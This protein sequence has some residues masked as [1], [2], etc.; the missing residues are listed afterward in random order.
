M[1]TLTTFTALRPDLAWPEWQTISKILL[2]TFLTMLLVDSVQRP[3]VLLLVIACS[4]GFYGFKGGLF[5]AMGNTGR[6]WGPEGSFIADN[7]GLG[8]ALNMTLPILFFVARGEPN[9]KLRWF[10]QA[11][12]FLSILAILFT[13]SRGAFLGLAVVVGYLFFSVQVRTKVVMICVLL[14]GVPAI[15]T[16]LP[17]QWFSRMGT[18]QE[19]DQD[20]SA[21]SRLDAWKTAYRLALDYPLT[22]GGFQ[23]IDDTLIY[24]QY[25]PTAV[26]HD[27]GVHSV[28][29]ELIGENGFVTFGLFVALMIS[30]VLSLRR[31]RRRLRQKDPDGL[32][33]YSHALEISIVAYAV[34][35]AFL[36]KAS[37]DLIYH[38]L[39]MVIVLKALVAESLRQTA[40]QQENAPTSSPRPAMAPRRSLRR[41]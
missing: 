39:A 16:V 20:G 24:A 2:M 3:R 35:G 30:S 31:I 37:F 33:N 9:K 26:D 5:V 19:V 22:G 25:N 23:I 28:Y 10:L 36:E 11:T 21:L 18:L 34:S 29:F 27:A 41:V 17:D 12:F 14:V 32:A 1:F 40:S 38:V 6:I 8:L 7:N 4:L 15:L 13:Y